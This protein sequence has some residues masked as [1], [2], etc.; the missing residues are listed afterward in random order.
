M[1]CEE[2]QVKNILFNFSGMR[3]ALCSWQVIAI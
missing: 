1:K 3:P 2:Q